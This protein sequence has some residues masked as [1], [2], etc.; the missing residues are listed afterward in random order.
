MISWSPASSRSLS[1]AGSPSQL[2][3]SWA[4]DVIYLPASLE[5]SIMLQK[6][7]NSLGN[8]RNSF[9]LCIPHSP[10]QV[11]IWTPASTRALMAASSSP[12][13]ERVRSDAMAA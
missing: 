5:R 6:G 4:Y 11:S 12:S 13:L 8:S 9:S 3:G 2:R 1:P 10:M 7:A